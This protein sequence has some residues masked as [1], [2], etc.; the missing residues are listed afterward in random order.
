MNNKVIYFLMISGLLF[1]TACKKAEDASSR[2]DPNAQE[3]APASPDAAAPSAQTTTNTVAGSTTSNATS[4]ANPQTATTNVT[5]PPA[6]AKVTQMSFNKKVHDFGDINQ[7]DKVSY[8]YTFKNT[9]NNDLIISSAQGSCGCTVPEYPKTP[10]KPG[11]SGTMKVSFDSAGKTGS[12]S[13]TVTIRANTATGVETLTIKANIKGGSP[14]TTT[15]TTTLPA[16]AQAQ[17]AQP[18]EENKN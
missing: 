7:G 6:N 2:I 18:A 8:N 4:V 16:P 15:T 5:M 3:I 14:V 1:V 13:K 17:P 10:I 11:K 12:Q 9:G